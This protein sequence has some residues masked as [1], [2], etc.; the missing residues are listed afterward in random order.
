MSRDNGLSRRKQF[1]IA[2][3]ACIAGGIQVFRVVRGEGGFL[4]VVSI[5][6]FFV[7]LVLT[8]WQLYTRPTNSD[9]NR[10]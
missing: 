8:G 2:G 9:P 6:S 10:L 7:V 5:L 3:A 4:A 1:F